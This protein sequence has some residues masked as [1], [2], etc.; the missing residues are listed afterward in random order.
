MAT[1]TVGSLLL[2]NWQDSTATVL[3]IFCDRAFITSGG[4]YVPQGSPGS[5]TAYKS[6]S[7]TYD[8]GAKTLTIPSFTIDST[9]DGLDITSARYSGFFFDTNGSLIKPFD[10][11][12]QFAVDNALSSTTWT[13]IRVFNQGSPGVDPI[14]FYTKAQVDAVVNSIT[15]NLATDQELLDSSGIRASDYSS[16]ALAVAAISSSSR[17]LVISSTLTVSSN[18]TIPSNITLQFLRNGRINFSGSSVLTINGSIQAGL[19]QIFGT[20]GGTVTMGQMVEQVYPQWWGAVADGSTDDTT[21]IQSAINSLGASTYGGVVYLP[22]GQYKIT[23]ALQIKAGVNMRGSGKDQTNILAATASQDGLTNLTGSRLFGLSFRDFSLGTVTGIT[24]GTAIKLLDVDRST[25]YNMGVTVTAPG[26]GFVTG[27]KV[28]SQLGAFHNLFLDCHI[29]A[30]GGAS[31][32]AY[33][34]TG[35]SGSGANSN[36]IIGGEA[37]SDSSTAILMDRGNNVIVEG[38]SVEGTTS[39]GIDAVGESGTISQLSVVHCRFEMSGGTI[40]VRLGALITGSWVIGN[41]F[42]SGITTKVSDLGTFNFTEFLSQASGPMISR[43]DFTLSN[44]TFMG[45]T[46]TYAFWASA[47]T[48]T[49]PKVA[50]KSNGRFVFGAGT[51]DVDISFTRS[52]AKTLQLEAGKLI[53][54]VYT[55][56]DGATAPSVADGT[57][58]QTANTGATTITNFATGQSGQIITVKVDANTTVQNNSSIKLAGAVDF[59]GS[60][61]DTITLINFSGV[62]YEKCR[63]VN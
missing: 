11:F 13:A 7:C 15:A 42:S 46:A 19:Y 43:G 36:K 17:T 39:I 2:E 25:F 61:S 40:G 55:F 33:N 16:L 3:R 54:A 47:V 22:V 44:G 30:K 6:L 10:G 29:R 26:P 14:E 49:F 56:A 24:G 59:V 45:H 48:D 53:S 57:V 62:W 32:Y 58:F 23:S 5:D 20:S 28:D 12:I 27:I 8:S 9:V 60:A 31:S 37:R 50:L 51:S 38:V 63:S 4:Q 18:L 35:A 52:A 41:L 34:L 21:A 1:I